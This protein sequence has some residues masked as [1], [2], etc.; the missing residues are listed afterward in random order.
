MFSESADLYGRFNVVFLLSLFEVIELIFHYLVCCLNLRLGEQCFLPLA[1][2][3][4][5]LIAGLFLCLPDLDSE[6]LFDLLLE[7]HL[8][9]LLVKRQVRQL[10]HEVEQELALC[11][12]KEER[13]FGEF[14]AV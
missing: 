9:T 7:L 2:K 13:F 1:F 6:P 11:F 10:V 14:E 12:S 5:L 8:H 3:L 4:E